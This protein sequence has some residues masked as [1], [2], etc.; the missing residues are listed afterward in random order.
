MNTEQRILIIEG[1]LKNCKAIQ[2]ALT[3][4]GIGV[5][6]TL[7]V[8]YGIEHRA[9][10]WFIACSVSA[11]ASIKAAI[12]KDPITMR[13]FLIVIRSVSLVLSAEQ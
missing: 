2:Y 13:L 3:E 1:D 6:Y 4:Y 10:Q 9:K 12:G 11:I 7:S 8:V 5:Y